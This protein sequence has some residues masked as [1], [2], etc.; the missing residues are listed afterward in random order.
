V[1]IQEYITA[2]IQNIEILVRYGRDTRKATAVAMEIGQRNV[3]TW[4]ARC[5]KLLHWSNIWKRN[6]Y[7]A[8]LC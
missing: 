1:Q 7:Q 5:L 3:T 8:V 2:A 4:V 6:N